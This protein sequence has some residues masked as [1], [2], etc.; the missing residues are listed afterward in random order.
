MLHLGVAA[1]IKAGSQAGQ[2]AMKRTGI[3]SINKDAHGLP[4]AG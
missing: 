1:S 3:I 4:A 2:K